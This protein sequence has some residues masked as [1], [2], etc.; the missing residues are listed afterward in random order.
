MNTHTDAPDEANPPLVAYHG[1]DRAF[2]TFDAQKTADGLFW[3][4][5]DLGKLLRRETGAAGH[6]IIMT[7]ILSTKKLA[8]WDEY[9]RFTIDELI[10]QGYD[11][12]QLDDDYV[13]FDPNQIRIVSTQNC[14]SATALLAR[15]RQ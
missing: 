9:D 2:K 7:V 1:T 14:D 6:G 3:L 10:H 12:L 8:G 4:T 13:V 15:P 5:S 11:G